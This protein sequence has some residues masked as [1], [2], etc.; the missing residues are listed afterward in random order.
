MFTRSRELENVI[1]PAWKTV[2]ILMA[3]LVEYFL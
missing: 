2:L 1:S 3:A